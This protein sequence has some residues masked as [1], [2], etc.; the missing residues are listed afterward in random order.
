MVL[1]VCRTVASM[2]PRLSVL[3][4]HLIGQLHKKSVAHTVQPGPVELLIALEGAAVAQKRHRAGGRLEGRQ[5][6]QPEAVELRGWLSRGP[7]VQR[8]A[9]PG[10]NQCGSALRAV[11]TDGT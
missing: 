11:F 8:I 10:I 7:N 3:P 4:P 1:P 6:I 5:Q 9:A 2:L